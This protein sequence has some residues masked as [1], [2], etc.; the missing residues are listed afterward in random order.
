MAEF[1][2][3][4][5]DSTRF[6]RR[7]VVAALFVLVCLGLLA[8]RF[9]Y[10][11]VVRHDYYLTR[12]EDNRIALLPAVPKR[13]T[14]VDRNGVVLAR[15]YAAYTLEITPSRAGDLEATIDGLSEI[16]AIEPR[17]RRRFRKILEESRNFDSVP[18]RTRLTDEEVARFIAQRY[19]F[20]GVEV[21]ARLFRDYPLG[22][23]ASHII[24]YIG[25]LN[26]RDVERIE[27]RGDSANYRGSEYIGKSGLEQ[28]YEAELHGQ[29][30][31]E[32]VEVNASG[33]AVRALAR[34]PAVPGSDLELT[35]DIELQKVAE[36]AFGKRR[37]ALVAIEPETGGVLALV[38]TPTFDPNL[39][40]DG[41]STQDWKELNDSP[42]HPLLNRAIFSA[43]PPGSTFKP[44]MAMAG[45]STGKRTV[46]GAIADPGYFNF[47][48]HR[49]MDDKVGGHGMV[50]LHKSI[51]VSC[52]TYYY[53]LA[54]DL[55]IDAIAGFMAPLG[56][57][58]RTGIDLPGEAEGVL[59][60]PE[61][62]KKRF[63][64]PELQ[65]WY[66]GETIS[67]GI[68]QGYNAY[69]PVQ[70]ANALAALV[71]DGR[72]YRPHLVRNVIDAGGAKRV[73]E[74][75]PLRKVA[76]N[77][78]HMAAVRAAMVDVNKAGTGARAF[79]GA[80]YEAGGKTGTAQVFSLRGGKYVEGRISERLRDHSWFIA[81]APAD[82]PRI[83]LAV[84]V[85]NGGFGAQSAAPIARQVIDY[86][87]LK[88][89]TDHP[90]DEDADAVESAE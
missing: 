70:L 23:T 40:V 83:A 77:P 1:R 69:T 89:R 41:I 61:W 22:A 25:R 44:F 17:D 18:V 20:P 47:G 67:V 35:L 79:R 30:G 27:E 2:T 86:L 60:S 59:P 6:R 11:Q 9:Y 80:P 65:R 68:G 63:R 15:N 29:T 50:D 3:P 33:R 71:N 82:K 84:L 58:S 62:K 78:A 90:A 46:N 10:L 14:I 87:L 54:N 88:S 45:L 85:E 26:Q 31:F 43:Y 12:A 4:D 66:G 49:F 28:S 76:L 57:G 55:G 36:A 51:V 13:G 21:Q 32:Q 56:F 75:E 52:N 81:Y 5:Q 38:S 72:L 53:Q 74:P 37:G 19:R 39:F 48:G 42:D 7:I 64:K 73:V 24:G 8:S 34:L 16:I